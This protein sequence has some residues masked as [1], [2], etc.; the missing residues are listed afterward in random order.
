MN[1]WQ[2]V[3]GEPGQRR[4]EHAPEDFAERASK[5]IDLKSVCK[6]SCFSRD[7][8]SW[9]ELKYKM[10]NLFGLIGIRDFVDAARVTE[11][12]ALH[13]RVLPERAEGVSKFLHGLLVATTSGKTLTAV[14]L[15][16]GNGFIAWKTLL[17]LVEPSRAVRYTAMLRGLLN[18]KLS[19]GKDFL[20]QWLDWGHDIEEYETASGQE[21]PNQTRCVTV[22][23][24]APK[25]IQ[26]FLKNCT[27]DCMSDYAVLSEQLKMHL[28]RQHL[29]DDRGRLQSGQAEGPVPMDIGALLAW[30]HKWQRKRKR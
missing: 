30:I 23:Q 25:S 6:P 8:A 16:G 18:P 21:I 27:I 24:W 1:G 9:P 28:L 7:E 15:A 10:E 17:E 4:M 5:I 11:D 3:G 26:N 12:R 19:E 29:Y 20:T 13:H 14:R 2:T 22:F